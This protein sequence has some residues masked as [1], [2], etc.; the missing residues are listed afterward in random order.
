[1]AGSM[2]A[3]P[4]ARRLLMAEMLQRAGN[5]SGITIRPVQQPSAETQ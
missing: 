5:Q 2:P 4:A 3:N 1:M